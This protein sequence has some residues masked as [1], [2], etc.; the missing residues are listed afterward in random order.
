MN[1]IIS[2]RAFEEAIE[3]TLLQ[4][5]AGDNWGRTPGGYCRRQPGDYDRELCLLSKDVLSFVQATQ[6]REWEKLSQ[7]YGADAEEQFLGRL[8]SEIKSRGALSVLRHGVK[9]MGCE[10]QLAYFRPVSGLNEETQRWYQANIFSV[11]RQL[12]YSVKH[13]NSLDMVL[14]LNGLPSFTAELKNPLTG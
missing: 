14:F 5:N 13:E 7:R 12:R 8:S 9:D 3:A 4:S 11:I 6:P 10:F 2:E 1:T